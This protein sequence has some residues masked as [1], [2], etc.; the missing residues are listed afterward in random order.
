V[1][2]RRP[3]ATGKKLIAT[4]PFSAEAWDAGDRARKVLNETDLETRRPR[5]AVEESGR[6]W[7]C[8]P[9]YSLS[10]VEEN[11]N[12]KKRTTPP[13]G[14][15]TRR[16]PSLV[17][18]RLPPGN[19]ANLY[20]RPRKKLG[21]GAGPHERSRIVESEPQLGGTVSDPY[22]SPCISQSKVKFASA[23]GEIAVK[24]RNAHHRTVRGGFATETVYVNASRF[25]C[26]VA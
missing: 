21:L 25:V 7:M 1:K 18:G 22:W 9:P 16:H 17:G 11:I 8:A 10:V 14:Q 5:A 6:S 23:L 3:L 24:C 15:P 12:K 4:G 19:S 20:L 2:Y 26:A 13:A